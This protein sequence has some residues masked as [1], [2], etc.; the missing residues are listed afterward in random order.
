MGGRKGKCE[1]GPHL[2]CEWSV[3]ALVVSTSPVC[4]GWG[5]THLWHLSCTM[6]Q[7]QK[8]SHCT[9]DSNL[10][11]IFLYISLTRLIQVVTAISHSKQTHSFN[12][13]FCTLSL[14]SIFFPLEMHNFLPI[15][16]LHS[17]NVTQTKQILSHVTGQCSSPTSII[18][19]IDFFS[20]LCQFLICYFFA[21]VHFLFPSWIRMFPI[22]AAD[23]LRCPCMV[24]GSY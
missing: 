19:F 5:P 11:P 13:I 17:F 14:G 3:G 20:P 1:E 23:F 16:L 12:T 8:R 22:S 10:D 18:L 15:P 4:T 7:S 2:Q 24:K 21:L 9:C 6:S